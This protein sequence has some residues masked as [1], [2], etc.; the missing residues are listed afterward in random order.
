MCFISQK[1]SS[2]CSVVCMQSQ[3]TGNV[4]AAHHA[5]HDPQRHAAKAACGDN[6]RMDVAGVSAM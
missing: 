4:I 3:A 5:A 6:M 1:Q 2:H